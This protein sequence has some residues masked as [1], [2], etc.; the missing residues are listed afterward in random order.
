MPARTYRVSAPADR[1]MHA[2]FYER[3]CV[4][5]IYLYVMYAFI[6]DVSVCERASMLCGWISMLCGPIRHE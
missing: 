5:P 2:C 6:S 4:S 3:I 1:C